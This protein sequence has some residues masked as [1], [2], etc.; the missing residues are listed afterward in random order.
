M[1]LIDSEKFDVAE[2]ELQ[3]AKSRLS[4]AADRD[5]LDHVLS[6][7]VTLNLS[8]EPSNLAK[9][10]SY[11]AEREQSI[12]TGYAKLQYA[13]TIYWSL[14][15]PSRAVAKAREAVAKGREEGDDRTVYQ[16]L[17]LLGLALLDLHENDQARNVLEDIGKMV[18]ARVRIVVGDETLFLERFHA[19]TEDQ[20]IKVTIQQIAQQ[21][22]AVCRDAEFRARLK[23]LA[24]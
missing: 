9:A 24:G 8:K 13:M 7:L 5:A 10:E 21:L 14:D 23:T 2:S 4:A 19:L 3:K 12:G 11:C 15:D 20:R 18:A 17:G 16:S 1:K 22:A 6:L